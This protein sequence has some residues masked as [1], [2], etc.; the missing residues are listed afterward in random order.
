MLD[1]YRLAGRDRARAFLRGQA[2]GLWTILD[3][4]EIERGWWLR[5]MLPELEQQWRRLDGDA[6]LPAQRKN[7]AG[8]GPGPRRAAA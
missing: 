6:T 7:R 4:I 5:V 3:M 2:G 8:A 1:K